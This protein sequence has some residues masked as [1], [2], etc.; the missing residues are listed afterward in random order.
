MRRPAQAE[1]E[2]TR[3]EH[4]AALHEH[5]PSELIAAL[6]VG[7]PCP[8]CEQVVTKKPKVR[9]GEADRARK[10]LEAARKAEAA[11][12]GSGRQGRERHRRGERRARG[13]RGAARRAREAGEGQA[14]CRGADDA[15]RRVEG[16]ASRRPTSRAS[17]AHAPR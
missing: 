13:A 17:G 3:E 9:V 6:V 7:E 8:V 2:R 5:V 14:R 15:A 12:S 11:R 16:G 1:A 4:E 10:A